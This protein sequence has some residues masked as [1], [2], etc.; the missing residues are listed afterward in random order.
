MDL[1]QEIE[2]FERL[3]VTMGEPL[4]VVYRMMEEERNQLITLL[5]GPV[6]EGQEHQAEVH[7]PVHPD[8]HQVNYFIISVRLQL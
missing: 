2:V 8:V 5:L 7:Q 4:E 6:E 3:A 1:N